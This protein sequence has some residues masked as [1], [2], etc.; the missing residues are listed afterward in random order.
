[1]DAQRTAR[2]PSQPVRRRSRHNVREVGALRLPLAGPY[3]PRARL[4]L[5]PDGRRL[6]LVRLWEYDRPVAHLVRTERLLAFARTN[7][8][9]RTVAE[10]EELCRRADAL[11]DGRRGDA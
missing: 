7:G 8:L 3:R 4:Y 2:T 1:M 6:W 10:I 5:F 9:A 11:E